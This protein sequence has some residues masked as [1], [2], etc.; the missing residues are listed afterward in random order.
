MFSQQPLQAD[1]IFSDVGFGR[2]YYTSLDMFQ[3]VRLCEHAG[4]GL[5]YRALNNQCCC[6]LV[7]N[8]SAMDLFV[9]LIV[10]FTLQEVVFASYAEFSLAHSPQTEVI[11]ASWRSI[12]HL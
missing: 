11:S 6:A 5:H 8:L 10:E 12:H 4:G 7:S 9:R 3:K 2:L 1:K